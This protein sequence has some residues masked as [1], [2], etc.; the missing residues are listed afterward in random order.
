[1]KPPDRQ[2]AFTPAPSSRAAVQIPRRRLVLLLAAS[3]SALTTLSGC[4]EKELTRDTYNFPGAR[5]D[6]SG[7]YKM[8]SA[9]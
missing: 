2:P 3:A 6:G 8:R 7:N 5:Q 4:G 9:Q 1:M